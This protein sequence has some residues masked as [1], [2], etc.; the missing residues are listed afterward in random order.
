[1]AKFRRR[2]LVEAVQWTG[3]NFDEVVALAGVDNVIAPHHPDRL[4]L[5]VSVREAWVPVDFGEWI[6]WDLAGC[7][8]VLEDA[9][10][11]LYEPVE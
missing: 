2:R 11:A 1:M 6:T 8:A 5:W 7:H 9:F 10:R 3:E 4:G